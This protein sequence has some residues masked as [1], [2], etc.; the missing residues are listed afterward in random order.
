MSKKNIAILFTIVILSG[1]T[2]YFIEQLDIP[3]SLLYSLIFAVTIGKI[4]FFLTH[5]YKKLLHISRADITYFSFLLFVATNIFLMVISF[6]AD[7]FC[8]FTID[9]TSFSGV[10]EANTV[11]KQIFKFFYLSFLLFTNMGVANVVPVT[12]AAECMVMFEAIISFITIIFILSDFVNLKD[13]LVMA[14][15]ERNKLKDL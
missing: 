5:S 4:Y 2:V 9:P 13:S 15:R 12:M 14:G 1:A 8:I 6:C 7:Y 3:R 11:P 10:E